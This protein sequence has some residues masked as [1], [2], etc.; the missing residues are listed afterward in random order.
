MEVT[1][2]YEKNYLK[3]LEAP[4]T[5]RNCVSGARLANFERFLHEPPPRRRLRDGFRKP[6]NG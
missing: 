3:V 2:A 1:K 4:D 5:E 6:N